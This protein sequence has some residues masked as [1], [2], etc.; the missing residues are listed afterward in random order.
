LL[1]LL[2]KLLLVGFIGL[3]KTG[4]V[5]GA[6]CWCLVLVLGDVCCGGPVV[7]LTHSHSIWRRFGNGD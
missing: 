7:S 2:N 5:L 1:L 3:L 6:W 4:L